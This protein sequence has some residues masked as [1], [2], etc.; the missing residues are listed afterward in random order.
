[1]EMV[2][3]A[4][5]FS[6]SKWNCLPAAES[7]SKQILKKKKKCLLSLIIRNSVVALQFVFED[8]FEKVTLETGST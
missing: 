1:M 4:A 7:Q 8:K 3:R 2:M 5:I 6:E